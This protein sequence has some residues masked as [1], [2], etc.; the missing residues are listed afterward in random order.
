MKKQLY[1]KQSKILKVF[2]INEESLR[3]AYISR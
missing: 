2:L 1:D 3:I